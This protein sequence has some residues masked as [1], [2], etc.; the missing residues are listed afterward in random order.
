[1]PVAPK[2][3]GSDEPLLIFPC[4]SKP[5]T[6]GVWGEMKLLLCTFPCSLVE[7][8]FLELVL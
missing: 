8:Q 5:G 7:T 4:F 3:S 1:M 2:V 6:Q